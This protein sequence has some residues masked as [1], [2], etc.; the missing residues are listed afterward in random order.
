[1]R[2]LIEEGSKG[3]RKEME[4]QSAILIQSGKTVEEALDF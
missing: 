1:M 3:V 4:N 2:K